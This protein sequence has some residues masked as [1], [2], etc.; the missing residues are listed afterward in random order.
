L[1]S[2]DGGFASKTTQRTTRRTR[3]LARR[4]S[5]ND[6]KMAILS[7]GWAQH[8]RSI[9]GNNDANKSMKA[10]TNAFAPATTLAERVNALI[11]EVDAAV[12]LV[13]PGGTVLRTHSWAKFGRTRSRP[14]FI[15]GS[16]IGTGPRASVVVIDHGAVIASSTVTI[17]A[18]TEIANCGTIEEL[19]A[20]AGGGPASTSDHQP[21]IQL[22]GSRRRQQRPAVLP[23]FLLLLLLSH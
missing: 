2:F 9:V 21:D 7:N 1:S 12:L 5:T 8:F 17:L 6:A 18:A 19:V 22:R 20:L 15:V 13:G 3:R 14:N 11:E 10:F 4:F 23:P 16:L